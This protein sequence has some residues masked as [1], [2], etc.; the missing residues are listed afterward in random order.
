MRRRWPHRTGLLLLLVS[1][2]AL[3]PPFVAGL[4]ARYPVV[5]PASGEQPRVLGAYHVHTTRSD[6]RGSIE[7]VATAARN[8]GL[9]F[10]VLTDHNVI[11]GP[12]RFVDGVLLIEGVELSTSAGHYVALGARGPLT[13]ARS[14]G[15]D[16]VRSVADSGG[17]GV[18]AHPVQHKNP[19]RD[20][21]AA[22]AAP[23]FELYSGD[24]FLRDA[25]GAPLTRLLPAAAG[26]LAQ[27][28]HGVMALVGDPVEPRERMLGL[29]RAPVALCAHDAHGFP[30]YE[31]VF[32]A[33]ALALPLEQLATAPEEA[34][35]QVVGAL[36]R[37]DALCVFRA[38]GG[39]PGFRLEGLEAGAR[40][41]RVGGSLVV[42]MPGGQPA[43]VRVWGSGVLAADGRT[44]RLTR[45][46][47]V[48]VEIWSQAP[49]RWWGRE[50][51][52]WLVA[53]PVE[54]VP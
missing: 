20:W 49:G 38:L 33:M 3:L 53:S 19:W 2:A 4:R 22:S 47:R 28:M 18:L 6:G 27:P 8:A 16:A 32:R 35:A 30:P 52:P 34:A 14:T 37:G 36:A 15:A 39:A 21:D 26:W 51:K 25:L 54:V 31:D 40:R 10:V 11:P 46:G 9:S 42:H 45:P 12:P 43:E 48:H 29:P 50:A 7:D 44:V 24:T 13:T 17:F 41:A 5:P 23:G 1:A